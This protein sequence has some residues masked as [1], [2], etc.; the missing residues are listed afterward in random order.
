MAYCCVVYLHMRIQTTKGYR[1]C[2][3]LS[4][5]LAIV[6]NIQYLEVR[7]IFNDFLTYVLIGTTYTII[8]PYY[9]YFKIKKDE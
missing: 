4:L 2:V 7:Q 1:I 5:L 6:L 8:S 9:S 3:A